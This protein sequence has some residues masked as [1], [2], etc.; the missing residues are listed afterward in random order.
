MPFL[1]A[2][3]TVAKTSFSAAQRVTNNL[4]TISKFIPGTRFQG[5]Q[6]IQ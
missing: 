3:A 5:V 1:T 6:P 4:R 2:V